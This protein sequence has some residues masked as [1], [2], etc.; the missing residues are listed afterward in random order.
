M[1]QF[2]LVLVAALTVAAVVFGVT[3]LVTGNDP[4]LVPVEPDGRAVPLPGTRPLLEQD[5]TQV[6][7]DTTLRGYRMAQVDQALRRAAYDIGYKDEL[8]EVLQAE[9]AALREGRIEDAD[10]LRR[11][12][13]AAV[14]TGADPTGPRTADGEP[15]IEVGMVSDAGPTEQS[16]T[17]ETEL[18]SVPSTGASEPVPADA[19]GS[20]SAA[21]APPQT[22]TDSTSAPERL[23]GATR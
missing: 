3:V 16:G 2:L 1:D 5:I 13:D 18:A 22:G 17:P 6:R 8:I 4:G 7:F 10:V 9:V 20:A 14:V 23:D 15:V 21:A 19:A 12:R 11:A